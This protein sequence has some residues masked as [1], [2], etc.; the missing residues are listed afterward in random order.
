MPPHERLEAAPPVA[1]AYVHPGQ[2]FVSAEATTVTTVLGSCVAVCLWDGVRRIGGLNHYML[3][4]GEGLGN[5]GLRYG[6]IAIPTLID[7]MKA[8]GSRLENVQAQLFGGGDVL[9]AF[10]KGEDSLGAKNVAVGRTLLRK[11]GIHLASEDVRGQRGRKV[12]FNT[13]DGYAT[14]F[15]MGKQGVTLGF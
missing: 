7:R 13:H 15:R 12:I 10:R 3:P 2:L 4:E 5:R 9:D 14:V 1:T 11:Y 6:T 8:M